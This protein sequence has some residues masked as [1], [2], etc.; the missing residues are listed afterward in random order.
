MTLGYAS[1]KNTIFLITAI[2]IIK[3]EDSLGQGSQKK[4][5]RLADPAIIRSYN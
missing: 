5:N 2:I 1:Q 3:I 4:H